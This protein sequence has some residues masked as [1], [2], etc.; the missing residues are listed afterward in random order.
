MS[1]YDTSNKENMQA[2]PKGTRKRSLQAADKGTRD[3]GSEA[4]RERDKRQQRE[5]RAAYRRATAALEEQRDEILRPDGTTLLTESIQKANELY[6]TVT[7]P[8]EAKLD[9]AFLLEA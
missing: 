4:L 1:Q 8:Q 3:I 9:S 5:T 6:Q 7:R 2:S